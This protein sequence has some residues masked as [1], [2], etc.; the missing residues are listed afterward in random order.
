MAGISIPVSYV[1]NRREIRVAIRKAIENVSRAGVALHDAREGC[2]GEA[3]KWI[4]HAG[5]GLQ[6][7]AQVYSERGAADEFYLVDGIRRGLAMAD[8]VL[9]ER[10]DSGSEIAEGILGAQYLF[11]E[12]LFR[13]S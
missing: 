4:A 2:A 11:L 9:E 1:M 13:I 6:S 5:C 8:T 10:G 7:V 3:L 12:D